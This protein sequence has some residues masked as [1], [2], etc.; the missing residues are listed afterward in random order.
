MRQRVATHK[1]NSVLE[2]ARVIDE[3][4]FISDGAFPSMSSPPK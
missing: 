3:W 1:T 2:R 4:S